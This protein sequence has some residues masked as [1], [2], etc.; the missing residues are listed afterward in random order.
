MRGHSPWMYRVRDLDRP[1]M[2]AGRRTFPF[3]RSLELRCRRCGDELDP[4]HP[5]GWE[6][7]PCL[8][9]PPRGTPGGI[10]TPEQIQEAYEASAR[11]TDS[12]PP[13]SGE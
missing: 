3:V 2:V 5:E 10:P 9:A 12:S 7:V 11:A 8:P 6:R 13:H 1:V 4:E